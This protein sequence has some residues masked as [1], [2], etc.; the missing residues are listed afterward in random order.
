MN[1]RIADKFVVRLPEGLRS[2]IANVAHSNHRSMN[3]EIVARLEFSLDNEPVTAEVVEEEVWTPC[4]GMLVET[5]AMEPATIRTL[6]MR[7]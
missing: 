4:I 3:S 1:S 6:V 7:D 5:P 2:R